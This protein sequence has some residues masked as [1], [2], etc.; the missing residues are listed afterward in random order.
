MLGGTLPEVTVTLVDR[1]DLAEGLGVDVGVGEHELA[2]RTVEREAV[3]TTTEREDEHGGSAVEGVSRGKE[4]TAGLEDISVVGSLVLGCDLLGDTKDRPDGDVGVDVGGTIEGIKVDDVVLGGTREGLDEDGLGLFL[5]GDGADDTTL[6]KGVDKGL[7][8][9]NVELLDG[10]SLAVLDT[11][12]TEETLESGPVDGAGDHLAGQLDLSDDDGEIAL[13]LDG[14]AKAT[15]E[16]V[17]VESKDLLEGGR[18]SVLEVLFVSVSVPVGFCAGWR[19]GTTNNDE[20]GDEEQQG[21][22]ESGKFGARGA[23]LL[24]DLEEEK[25]KDGEVEVC[26]RGPYR[27]VG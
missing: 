21:R 12:L 25:E 27:G 17:L 24:K 10:L 23:F 20:D 14:V 3:D 5:R 4:V 9:K 1:V 15:L 19:L 26:V 22:R 8:G 7:V 13:L 16:E 18:H 11:G 6:G 2:E